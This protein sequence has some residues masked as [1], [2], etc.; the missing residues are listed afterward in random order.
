[1]KKVRMIVRQKRVSRQTAA[2]VKLS[3]QTIQ[4]KG[5]AVGKKADEA[6]RYRRN[7]EDEIAGAA[8]YASLAEAEKDPVRKDL[9]RQLAEAEGDHADLWRK[10]LEAAGVAVPVVR[11]PL[12]VRMVG[13][14][15]RTAGVAFVLP[16]VANAEFADRNKYAGQ[17]DA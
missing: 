3:H 9:F 7:F 5:S 8:M 1:M 11:L 14:L 16:T 4:P 10:K 2:T 15:A 6:Q 12:K 17:H 13:W